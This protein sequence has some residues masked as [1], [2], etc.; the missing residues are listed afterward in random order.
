MVGDVGRMISIDMIEDRRVVEGIG[1]REIE[2]EGGSRSD[3][4]VEVGW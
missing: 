2:V 3:G 4:E 1:R